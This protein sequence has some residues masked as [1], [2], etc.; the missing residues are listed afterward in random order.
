MTVTA[1]Q[2]NQVLAKADVLFDAKA[3]DNALDKM[4]LAISE[5]FINDELLLLCVMVGGLVPAAGLFTRLQRPVQLDYLHATRYNGGLVGQELTWLHKPDIDLSG[6]IILV[7]DDILDEGITLA[8]ILHYCKQQGARAVYSAVL[9]EKVHDRKVPG[10]SADFIGLQVE[11]RYVFG[12][13]MDY[14]GYM[15]NLTSIYAVNDCEEVEC[16]K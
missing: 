5:K 14:H 16:Q 15:R 1:H 13:G 7:V 8:A 3:V 12:C 9:V 4:T 2:A 6:R 11:D 10:L